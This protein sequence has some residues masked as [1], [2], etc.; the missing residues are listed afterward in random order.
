MDEDD[1][2]QGR[3]FKCVSMSLA[4][5]FV[6]PLGLETADELWRRGASK[7]LSHGMQPQDIIKTTAC[8]HVQS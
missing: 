2:G 4:P 3:D 1:L 5:T 7:G 8:E 6:W